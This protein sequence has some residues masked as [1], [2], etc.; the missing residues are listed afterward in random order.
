MIDLASLDNKTLAP[1]VGQTMTLRS[2]QHSVPLVLES[3]V[4]HGEKAPQAVREPFSIT[5]R[6]ASGL[7]IPQA[8]YRVEHP[9]LGAMEIFITQVGDGP[10]GS[11]F[12][13]IFS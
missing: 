2:G 7:R 6:G 4:V 12:E 3:I 8:I 5:F 11:E 9:E 13:S 10:K 1:L